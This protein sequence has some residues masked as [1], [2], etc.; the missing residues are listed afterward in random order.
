MTFY[1]SKEYWEKRYT[2]N[3]HPFEWYVGYP[4]L[5]DFLRRHI[6]QGSRVMVAG[7][8][9]SP[10][11]EDLYDHASLT[12]ITAVDFC[13]TPIQVMTERKGGREGLHYVC[14]DL[15]EMAFPRNTFDCIIDKATLD[16]RMCGSE[17]TAIT[18]SVS[19]MLHEI[20]RVLKK[21]GLYLCI[22]HSP[23]EERQCLYR[24][25]LEWDVE[26]EHIPKVEMIGSLSDEFEGDDYRHY[27]A[28][29]CRKHFK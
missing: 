18:R 13:P 24:P 12:D 5:A 19:R 6:R 1:G 11:G 29:L 15:R 27:F 7:C 21:G 25:D 4:A 17:D 16:S 23:P 28:Y 9:N 26:V 10:L 22:S 3:P 14:M 2:A 8:G 20:S